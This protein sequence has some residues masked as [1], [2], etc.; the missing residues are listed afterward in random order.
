VRFQ[1]GQ[2][3]LRRC[4]QRGQTISSVAYGR[5]VSD[6]E[7]GL[8]LWIADGSPL[9]WLMP[10][11]ER[12][13]HRMPFPELL[14]APKRLEQR[15]WQGGGILILMPSRTAHSVWW[16]WRDA[17]DGFSGWYVN[18]EA[19]ATRWCDGDVAGVDTVDQDLDI[20][21]RPDRSWQ[22]KDEEDFAERNA[23]PEHYWVDDPAAVRAE[24]E[25]LVKL[26]EAGGFPFDGT[27][28]DFRPDQAWMVPD[29]FPVGWDRPRAF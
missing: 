19:P 6:D 9:A 12:S 14:R 21:V 17:R 5:V 18:L 1:P 8:L 29:E 13:P 4:F 3:V 27:W 24:G 22:W 10:V 23:Y 25:R 20:V 16:F 15:A 26:I 28:C 2:V 11:D 7:R